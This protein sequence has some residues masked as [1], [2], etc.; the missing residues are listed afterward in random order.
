MLLSRDEPESDAVFENLNLYHE[1]PTVRDFATRQLRRMITSSGLKRITRITD[2]VRQEIHVE[3]KHDTYKGNKKAVIK[4]YLP[5]IRAD[6]KSSV[7]DGGNDGGNEEVP[8]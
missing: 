7:D 2:L 8:F 1:K 4:R 6:Q 3:L 5:P